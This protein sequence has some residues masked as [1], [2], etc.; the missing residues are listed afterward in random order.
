MG[1]LTVEGITQRDR[2]LFLSNTLII[3]TLGMIGTLV[4]DM[5]NVIADP[6]VSYDK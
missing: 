4:A 2:E 5:C 6:R 1:K 3:L